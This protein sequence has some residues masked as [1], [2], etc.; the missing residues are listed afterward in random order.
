M[1]KSIYC[2]WSLLLQEI[3]FLHILFFSR[4]KD[5]HRV[6]TMD[7]FMKYLSETVWPPSQRFMYCSQYP[8]QQQLDCKTK[9]GNPFGPFWD[10][11]HI[12][13]VGD[14]G[15]QLRS[16]WR[17]THPPEKHFVIA[18]RGAPATFPVL[19]EHKY[20]SEFIAWNEDFQLS[21]D[22]WIASHLSLPFL[23]VHVRAGSD[24][25]NACQG[26]ETFHEYMSSPQCRHDEFITSV[27][28]DSG[29]VVQCSPCFF[30]ADLFQRA[31]LVPN[32]HSTEP[33]FP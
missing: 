30:S 27:R 2:S 17:I 24:W 3:M 31:D 18:L 7:N 22:A 15:I 6:I 20:I 23:G 26:I 8:G 25:L 12:D 9:Q 4:L 33:L 16:N 32:T 29:S 14:R 10:H 28:V 21:A 19:P 5:F 13:F 1:N 11:F